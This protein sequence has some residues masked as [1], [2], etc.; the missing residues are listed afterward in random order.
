MKWW[1]IVGIAVGIAANS[2]VLLF[3]TVDKEERGERW[4]EKSLFALGAF[5]L[6]LTIVSGISFYILYRNYNSITLT[7]LLWLVNANITGNNFSVFLKY[8]VSALF[9]IIILLTTYTIGYK[10]FCK[11]GKAIR[12][13][14]WGEL[15]SSCNDDTTWDALQ[16]F[17]YWFI[18]KE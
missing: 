18:Y 11:R 15:L 7:E 16:A 12:Y 17:V 10:K 14:A 1:L 4:K 13:A 3:H 8:I 9:L 5:E 6:F 2:I